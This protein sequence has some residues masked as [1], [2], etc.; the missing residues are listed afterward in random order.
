MRQARQ[1]MG[2]AHYELG[3]YAA[4]A[5]MWRMAVD[6]TPL[7]DTAVRMGLMRNIGIALL[8]MELHEAGPPVHRFR[9]S[10][11]CCLAC[12]TV[13]AISLMVLGG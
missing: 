3:D 9:L 4:A 6:Q 1:D 8:R 11:E 7:A 13:P 12:S 2:R 10:A 5:K